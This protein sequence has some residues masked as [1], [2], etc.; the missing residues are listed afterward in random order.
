M[1]PLQ[2]A[3]S[4]PMPPLSPVS[5][6]IVPMSGLIP[7]TGTVSIGSLNLRWPQQGAFYGNTV[8]DVKGIFEQMKNEEIL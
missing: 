3:C 1:F 4:G 8:T 7:L 2:H 5:V 6:H